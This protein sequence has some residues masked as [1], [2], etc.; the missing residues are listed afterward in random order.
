[1]AALRWRIGGRSLPACADVLRDLHTVVFQC[2]TGE[3]GELV[4]ELAELAGLVIAA[5]ARGGGRCGSPRRGRRIAVRVDHRVGGRPR[6][7][8]LAG[9]PPTVAKAAKLLRR[10]ELG[11]VAESMLTADIDPATAVVVGAEYDKLVKDLKP[12]AAP[13]VLEQMLAWR[14]N[15][16]RPGCGTWRQEILANFGDDRRVRE[17]AGP[18]PTADRPDRRSGNLRRGVGLPA[19]DRQR[20][21]RHPRSRHRHARRTP[22]EPGRHPRMRGR[23][24]GAAVRR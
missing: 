21:P 11:A 1:M 9:R 8:C 4:G 22:A 5:A 7:A 6:L 15:T 16:A 3:L 18:V 2:P 19:E 20:G 23:S 24:V 14:R 17:A 10:P 12:D 13:V